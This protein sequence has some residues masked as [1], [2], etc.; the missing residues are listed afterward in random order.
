[1]RLPEP[2]L[3]DRE[4]TSCDTGAWL[5]CDPSSRSTSASHKSACASQ[6]C[7][8]SHSTLHLSLLSSCSLLSSASY[9][10]RERQMARRRPPS[11]PTSPSSV[12]SSPEQPSPASPSVLGSQPSPLSRGDNSTPSRMLDTRIHALH[13]ELE[14]LQAAP[15][16]ET[17]LERWRDL[18]K[19]YQTSDTTSSV[20]DH[21]EITTFRE[22]L[23]R[24]I[25]LQLSRSV[26]AVRL[27]KEVATRFS[28]AP[29]I[30]YALFGHV[31]C[32]SRRFMDGLLLLGRIPQFTSWTH[33]F[34]R[35]LQ[36][37]HERQTRTGRAAKQMCG[38]RINDEWTVW[39]IE[40]VLAECEHKGWTMPKYRR[41]KNSRPM[42][43]TGLMGD[44]AGRSAQVSG[45]GL[46]RVCGF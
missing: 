34:G 46:M 13:K 5:Q 21:L 40:Q 3:V 28:I 17:V 29:E 43:K 2:L 26:D 19:T 35:L 12:S 36:A 15:E 14:A 8:T 24:A 4:L 10:V 23:L 7:Q 11:P 6:H 9:M 37:K 16:T 18:W 45:S 42:N 1:M 38:V 31:G 41:Y 25:E 33:I 27:F 32:G 44:T 30:V 20:Q 22:H 39:D